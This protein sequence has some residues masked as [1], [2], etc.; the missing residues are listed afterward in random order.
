MS[1]FLLNEIFC[2]A[3]DLRK[4][5]CL[6]YKP[7]LIGVL[8]EYIKRLNIAQRTGWL[9]SPATS[10]PLLESEWLKNYFNDEDYR[11]VV[12][13]VNGWEPN[14]VLRRN[15]RRVWR[16][17]GGDR[18]VALNKFSQ[19]RKGVWMPY[20]SWVEDLKKSEPERK[21]FFYFQSQQTLPLNL[22]TKVPEW[23]GSISFRYMHNI[24]WLQNCLFLT[25]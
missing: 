16:P 3:R 23:P 12:K 1:Q 17:W 8:R 10:S 19:K 2:V 24:I 22:C 18:R 7:R 4:S 20:E 13:I 6:G 25:L 15:D 5:N 9:E 21:G 14:K 11:L